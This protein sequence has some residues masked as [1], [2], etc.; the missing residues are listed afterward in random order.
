MPCSK[1]ID[2]LPGREPDRL[3]GH[4]NVFDPATPSGDQARELARLGEDCVPVG[5]VDDRRCV[6]DQ[7]LNRIANVFRA[8]TKPLEDLTPLPRTVDLALTVEGDVGRVLA[9]LVGHLGGEQSTLHSVIEQSVVVGVDLIG[10]ALELGRLQF[11]TLGDLGRLEQVLLALALQLGRSTRDQVGAELNC[12]LRDRL[13]I[14]V[15]DLPCLRVGALRVVVGDGSIAQ[16]VS[17]MRLR[18][19]AARPGAG[20]RSGGCASGPPPC[21]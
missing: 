20:C 5:G 11:Q 8:A 2:N 18:R 12:L 13:Q 15:R 6:V 4:G 10:R 14:S 9:K 21:A 19:A 17:M 3:L 1:P 16:P 7:V